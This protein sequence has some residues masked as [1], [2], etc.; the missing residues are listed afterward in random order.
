MGHCLNTEGLRHP[1]SYQPK[2]PFFWSSPRNDDPASD[3]ILWMFYLETFIVILNLP[4]RMYW[5][6]FQPPG[7]LP[8]SQHLMERHLWNLSQQECFN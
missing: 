7:S 6:L 1:H 3:H 5:V 4:L 2:G 8:W